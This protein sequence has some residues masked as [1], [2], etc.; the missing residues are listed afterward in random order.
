MRV[1]VGVFLLLLATLL[2]VTLLARVDLLQGTAELVLLTLIA[3]MMQE[4]WAPDWRWGIPAGLMVGYSSALPDWLLLAGYVA[5][6]AICQLL[7]T[8]VWQVRLLTLATSVL[9]G[10]LVIH[11]LTLLYMWF[12]ANPMGFGEALNLITLP[13]MLLNLIL[14]L[15]VNAL[16]S[17]LVKFIA[18]A[19]PA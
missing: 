19:E 17:E 11:L 2:Q 12:G 4:G 14:L 5:A 16:I 8:R 7:H 18:P 6:A 9:L 3:W 1:A 13:S 10:T 15:P